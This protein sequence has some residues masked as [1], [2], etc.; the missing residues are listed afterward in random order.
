MK[1]MRGF[2][3]MEVLIALVILVIAMTTLIISSSDLTKNNSHLEDKGVASWVA[4]N[5]I[6]KARIGLI[7]LGGNSSHGT[8]KMANRQWQW[9]VNSFKT[10]D[11]NTLR[12]VV[13]VSAEN[14]QPAIEM[15]GYLKGNSQ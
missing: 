11:K 9:T 2:T 6:A 10:E 7:S 13:S 8:E 5:V 1:K 3:L 15:V 14:E 4:A 12:I